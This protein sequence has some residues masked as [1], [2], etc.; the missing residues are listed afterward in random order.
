VSFSQ[1][2]TLLSIMSFKVDTGTRARR[3]RGSNAFYA[4][5]AMTALIHLAKPYYITQAMNLSNLPFE[6]SLRLPLL[7]DS[8][9]NTS[10]FAHRVL[11]CDAA[12]ANYSHRWQFWRVKSAETVWLKLQLS[13][14]AAYM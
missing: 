6:V 13:P 2:T 12:S 14:A 4:N 1:I 10:I 8:N 3:G 11:P 9:I 5:A 7:S